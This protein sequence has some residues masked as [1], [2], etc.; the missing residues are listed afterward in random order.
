MGSQVRNLQ[1]APVW[2]SGSC[3]RIGAKLPAKTPPI[4]FLS[5]GYATR[6]GTRQSLDLWSFASSVDHKDGSSA[7]LAFLS[8]PI[9]EAGNRLS[10]RNGPRFSGGGGV[11]PFPPSPVHPW[12]AQTSGRTVPGSV[13]AVGIAV[14]WFSRSTTGN[15]GKSGEQADPNSSVAAKALRSA[16]R[17]SEEAPVSGQQTIREVSLKKPADPRELSAVAIRGLRAGATRSGG[18]RSAGP[19]VS[20]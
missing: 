7:G 5:L 13:L 1:R 10:R 15:V 16:G 12:L 11:C 9:S 3:E 17:D 4:R 6:H 20:R 8:L 2:K 14:E 19:M 18:L